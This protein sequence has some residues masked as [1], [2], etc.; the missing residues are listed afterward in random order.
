MCGI[1]MV[2]NSTFGNRF[3]SSKLNDLFGDMMLASAVRGVDATGLFQV[4]VAGDVWYAKYAKPSGQAMSISN[5]YGVAKDVDAAAIT[6]GH[7][8]HAT[9]GSS[10][11][12]GNSHPFIGY[13]EDTNKNYIIGVHNGTL[14][15][16]ESMDTHSQ[17]TTDSSWAISHIAQLGAAAFGDFFGAFA[18][19]WH[20]TSHPDKV[21]IARNNDRPFHIARTKNG[22]SIIGCSEAKMLDWL[23]DRNGLELDDS[24]IYSVDSG[25]IWSID[26]SK[27]QLTFTMEEEIE[28]NS[29]YSSYK[30][31]RVVTAPPPPAITIKAGGDACSIPFTQPADITPW[32]E[33]ED[34]ITVVAAVK[35]ALRAARYN[36][37]TN[38]EEDEDTPIDAGAS[39]EI[40]MR[41]KDAWFS[42]TGLE[43]ADKKRAEY[44]GSFGSIVM[45][46]PV[47][48]DN[49]K[50]S[51]VGEITYP[52]FYKRPIT[53][54]E[55]VSPS[56]W[57]Q[58]KN[59]PR[60]MVV[61]GLRYFNAEKEYIVTNLN[62]EGVRHLMV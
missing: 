23:A 12:D 33:D 43:L 36:T 35:S 21:F 27:E 19:V 48:Y 41:A 47:D 25:Y 14:W 52:T 32:G 17:H 62:D 26:T 4:D 24:A 29:S 9:V 44:D 5:M 45:F 13:K 38:N 11:D 8:R 6:V 56:E 2:V 18:I 51:V 7:V 10:S 39:D 57:S 3:H 15:G 30:N 34:K 46:D 37:V 22:R 16:W 58:I 59:A 50:D 31:P 1:A 28:L 49:L 60:H 55:N 42:T 61:V 54:V 40:L 20:D 53:Y